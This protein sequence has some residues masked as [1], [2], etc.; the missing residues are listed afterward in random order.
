MN[1]VFLGI[2]GKKADIDVI[3]QLV[4]RTAHHLGFSLEDG[5]PVQAILYGLIGNNSSEGKITRLTRWGF[6][7]EECHHLSLRIEQ[8]PDDASALKEAVKSIFPEIRCML[9]QAYKKKQ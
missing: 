9:I 8:S 3:H 1:T 4:M 7:W 6:R 2:T 5:I